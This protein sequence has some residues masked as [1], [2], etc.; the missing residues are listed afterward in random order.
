MGNIPKNL[1]R[2]T[3]YH[4]IRLWTYPTKP[5]AEKL[6]R[7]KL[8]DFPFVDDPLSALLM[9]AEQSARDKSPVAIVIAKNPSVL[10]EDVPERNG[11]FKPTY[12]LDFDEIEPSQLEILL[13]GRDLGKLTNYD[14]SLY[15]KT[16]IR[17]I[18]DAKKFGRNIMNTQEYLPEM[19]GKGMQ[20]KW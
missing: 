7:A 10:T 5:T 15:L 9:A 4:Q 13:Q 18:K 6:L 3:S 14:P 12:H 20:V 8:F 16:I 1:Y 2:G 17:I 19:R 11:S